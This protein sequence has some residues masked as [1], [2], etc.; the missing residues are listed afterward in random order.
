MRFFMFQRNVSRGGPCKRLFGSRH[1]LDPSVHEYCRKELSTLV[2][3]HRSLLHVSLLKIWLICSLR[4]FRGLTV[5]LWLGSSAPLFC[6]PSWKPDYVC[7]LPSWG[8]V[9]NSTDRLKILFNGCRSWCLNV[10]RNPKDSVWTV[11][12]FMS[13][14]PD[15]FVTSINPLSLFLGV[16]FH[17]EAQRGGIQTRCSC[18]WTLKEKFRWRSQPQFYCPG[19]GLR[20]CLRFSIYRSWAPLVSVIWM[21]L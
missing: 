20:C 5:D 21:V 11:D 18:L 8:V 15:I 14:C 7:K 3:Q 13:C 19:R 16:L 2:K 12:L 9:N 10:L 17:T 6:H 1:M 4:L